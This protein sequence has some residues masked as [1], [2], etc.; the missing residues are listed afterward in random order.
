[1]SFFLFQIESLF[2]NIGDNGYTTDPDTGQWMVGRDQALEFLDPAAL[3]SPDFLAGGGSLANLILVG[4]DTLADIPPVYQ[5]SGRLSDDDGAGAL[6]LTYWIGVDDGLIYRVALAGQFDLDQE[7]G[8]ALP[9]G[10]IGAGDAAFE[11]VLTL[12]DFGK[13]VN[14]EAP[15]IA[16]TPT[17]ATEG[18]DAATSTVATPPDSGWVRHDATMDGFAVAL[19][20]SWEIVQLDPE[21]V[22]QSLEPLRAGEPLLADRIVRQIGLLPATAKVRL[23]GFDRGV[24]GGGSGADQHQRGQSGRWFRAVSGHLGNPGDAAGPGPARA[25]RTG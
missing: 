8:D 1:M 25:R 7:L 24:R 12:S 20:P 10:D 3:V 4:E 18:T 14:I 21:D 17:G 6:E 13:P 11:A 5:L 22:S 9:L 2:I 16:S 15:D 19:P 23:F